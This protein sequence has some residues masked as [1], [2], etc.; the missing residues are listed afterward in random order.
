MRRLSSILVIA[1]SVVLFAACGD[2]DEKVCD[3][4]VVT[5]CGPGKL[6]QA[7][8]D[9]NPVCVPGCLPDNPATC[10]ADQACEQVEGGTPQCFAPVV[11]RGRIFKALDSSAIVGARIAARDDA[12]AVVGNVVTS[13]FDGTYDLRL[14]AKR[15][16]NGAPLSTIYTLRADAAGFLTFPGG[17]RPAL[18]ID[19]ATAV[20]PTAGGP[21]I[22]QN[23]ATSI[24]LLP[25]PGAEGA[26]TVRGVVQTANPGGTLVAAGGSTGVAD[27]SGAFAVFNVAAGEVSVRGFAA[28]IQIVPATANVVAGQEASGIVLTQDAAKPLASI[29]GDVNIVNPEEGNDTTSVSLVLEETFIESLEIGEVPRGL[30]ADGISNG[31]QITGVPDGRYVVLASLDND[32]LVRDPDPGIAGTQIV[33]LQVENGVPSSTSFSFKVTGALAV[34]SPGAELPEE[35]TGTPTFVWADDAGAE[36]FEVRVFDALGDVIWTTTVP[37]PNGSADL[38]LAYGGTEAL[39]P[40]MVY[41]FRVTSFDR[42]GDPQARTEELRGVFSVK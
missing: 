21:L 13:S 37:N 38:S 32:G 3:T 24:G 18:P 35:V 5:S 41:Q 20:A 23:A 22:V 34:R 4:S 36:T 29:S 14:A 16:A 33:H 12:G 19:L 2:D 15:S 11:V 28:G 39:Q 10:T 25:F 9:G 8:P 42:G 40:G 1:A 6:C 7:D 17:L 26:G 31:F 30:R 27:A